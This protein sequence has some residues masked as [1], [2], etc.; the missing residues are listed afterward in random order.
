M[1]ILFDKANLGSMELSNRMIRTASH[2]GLADNRGRPTDEQFNF[3]KGFIEGGIG[4][5]I[6]G[7]A[8][9]SQQGKSAL[10]HMTMID[11]D[12]LIPS[13]RKLVDRIHDIGGKIVLQI[14]HCG[15]QTWSS[16][17]GKPLLA[18]SQIPC[19]FYCEMPRE[20]TESQILKVIDDFSRAAAR[21]R[22]SGYDGVQI[23][24]AHGYLLSTFLSRHANKRIDRWGGSRENR[25]RIVAETLR[26]VRKAVGKDYPV[27]IKL[28]TYERAALGTKPEDCVEFAGMVQGTEC[29]DAIELSCGT[30]EGGFIMARGKFPTDALLKYMRPYC[31]YNSAI[32]FLLKY[33]VIPFIKLV[34]PPFREGYN[35]ETA[36]KIKQAVSLPIITVGGMR[37]SKF[38]NDA[39]E[40]N[41]TDFVSMARPL[42]L[43]PNLPNK[44][45]SG[46]SDTA[47]CDNC[48]Q[49]VVAVDTG[50]IR[51]HNLNLIDR[52]R[53][54]SVTAMR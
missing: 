9:I 53:S 5:V 36:A 44:F 51:C 19:G 41:M 40:K 33:F 50:P 3:Y 14:C 32:K 48:N 16:E 18:P 17:T 25:F 20:I 13:H 22:E 27:L 54:K 26:A 45:R 34:Q 4:L 35:L 6:T 23:H 31:N 38:L 52:V 12:E 8:G 37:S 47:L 49:C 11:S 42:I 46:T 1:S 21:A 30:N 28:N 10:Y 2:E 15:R 43:E 39:I 29:C 7:Y 24:G